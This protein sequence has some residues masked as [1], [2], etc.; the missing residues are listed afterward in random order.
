MRSR[1]SLRRGFNLVELLI[2]IIII[3]ALMAVAV[4]SLLNSRDA[5]DDSSAQQQL[6]AAST[7]IQTKM[8][9]SNRVPAYQ[10]L[11]AIAPQ[12]QIIDK[13]VAGAKGSGGTLTVSASS[14]NGTIILATTGGNEVCWGV[15]LTM[16]L[17][18]FTKFTGACSAQLA[19]NATWN[20]FGFPSSDPSPSAT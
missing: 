17:K 5:A 15:K 8:L 14:T 20:A 3:G 16:R 1:R 6:T 13:G 4:P 10:E 11:Q 9:R 18:E 19:E 2:V 12:I 7:E